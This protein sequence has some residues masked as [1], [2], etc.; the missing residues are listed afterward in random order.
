M[1]STGP[2]LAHSAQSAQETGT[3]PRAHA[4]VGGFAETPLPIQK[5]ERQSL[6]LF[7]RL[8]DICKNT[9][10]LLFLHRPKSTTANSAGRAPVSLYRPIYS[11]IGVLLWQRP[12]SS[13]NESFPST[14]F[15][16]GAL[17]RSVHGDSGHHGQSNA[18]PMI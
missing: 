3:R 18:F 6:A 7:T 17:T 14:N 11:M 15:T 16:N 9:A 1:N 4:R 8:T 10:A 2:K 12:N 13:P 5:S